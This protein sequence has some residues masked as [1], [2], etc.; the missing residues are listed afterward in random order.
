M[1]TLS[2]NCCSFFAFDLY[3]AFA[4]FLSKKIPLPF[5]LS[6]WLLGLIGLLW[7]PLVSHNR[8]VYIWVD[9]N[10]VFICIFILKTIS[11]IKNLEDRFW[12][13]L[14]L[15]CSQNLFKLS[16]DL[17]LTPKKNLDEG[18]LSFAYKGKYSARWLF[19]C[20]NGHSFLIE[21][22]YKLIILRLAHLTSSWNF[23]NR[24]LFL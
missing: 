5:D 17:K 21:A 12:K 6:T 4:F 10:V 20:T 7:Q 18:S 14:W 8:I 13:K 9:F 2:D 15:N 11:F 24:H 22:Y 16:E 23:G 3:T 19:S 1:S